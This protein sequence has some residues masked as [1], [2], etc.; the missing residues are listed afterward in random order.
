[1]H[2]SFLIL[3][4]LLA[5]GGCAADDA[6][7]NYDV[8]LRGGTVYDGSG[9][10]PVRADVGIRG[11]TVA[12]IG[13]LT[14]AR[15]DHVLDVSGLAVAPGFIN[16]HSWA[17]GSLLL[18]GRSMSNLKQGVTTE[19]FGEGVT[20]GPL[21]DRLRELYRTESDRDFPP[22]GYDI[23]WETLRGYLLH[24]ENRGVTP[25]V[26]SFVGA[27]TLRQ[28]VIGNEDR[29]PS[30]DELDRMTELVSSEMRGGALGLGSR[31]AY[32]PANYA[33]TPELVALARASSRYGGMYISHIRSEANELLAALDEFLHIVR[34]A[35]SAGTIYHLKAAGQSNWGKM[36]SVI[37]LIR[38]ARG[39]GLDI[40]ATVY[41]YQAGSTGLDACLPPWAHEGGPDSLRARLRDPALRDSIASDMARVPPPWENYCKLSGSPE[42]V[43]LLQFTQDSLK[44]LQ[45]RSLAEV[46]RSRGVSPEVATMDLVLHDR[47]LVQTAYFLMSDDNLRQKIRQPWVFFGS[48][49]P[50]VAAD[51][52]F[53]TSMVHPRAYG[54]FA[55][56][57]S[58][59]VRDEDLV[60]LPE[61]IR[62]MT[63]LPASRFDL[64]GRGLLAPGMYAD[65][66]VFDPARV[67]DRAT[68]QEPHRYAEGVV[69]VLVNGRPALSEGEHTGQHP[70][71]ALFR[72]ER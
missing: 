28:Y 66:V 64:E 45:G 25:N 35:P 70:G 46:A 30:E 41:P 60:S 54:T 19:V 3:V 23:T 31:L 38:S 63:S 8:L 43:L 14:G 32:A 11:D 15:A 49:A 52:T 17:T 68:Y 29:S 62:R 34:T 39:D 5:L 7:P 4:L 33:D 9:A 36:D 51:S 72:N 20:M 67:E 61:A 10:P 26:A 65:V 48:D 37:S 53:I 44:H 42:N 24:L 1:M 58:D 71:R 16:A 27:T 57:L 69:H 50:S 59:Y 21:N 13:D 22:P 47:S 55:K 18:D 6:P 12:A 56:I 40:T 2:R